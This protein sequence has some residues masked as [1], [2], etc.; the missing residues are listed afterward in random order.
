MA[1]ILAKAAKQSI[2]P[3]YREPFHIGSYP[4]CCGFNIIQGF[5]PF[6]ECTSTKSKEGVYL[7]INSII[8]MNKVNGLQPREGDNAEEVIEFYKKDLKE[9]FK[10]Y[11]YPNRTRTDAFVVPS[12]ATAGIMG[13]VNELQFKL[14]GKELLELGFKVIVNAAHSNG[15]NNKIYVLFL[16][17]TKPENTH[18]IVNEFNLDDLYT[19]NVV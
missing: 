7:R 3:L 9:K 19:Q 13:T 1:S 17:F 5:L 18:V 11:I 8:K 6:V 16:E 15:H 4:G 2:A 10:K 14:I 12:L